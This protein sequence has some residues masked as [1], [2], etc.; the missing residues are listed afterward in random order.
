MRFTLATASILAESLVFASSVSTNDNTNRIQHHDSSTVLVEELASTIQE[1]SM[2]RMDRRG[3]LFLS[4]KPKRFQRTSFAQQL[5]NLRQEKTAKVECDPTKAVKKD[6]DVGVLGVCGEYQYCMESVDSTLG[7][8]CQ[9]ETDDE[10]IDVDFSPRN[11]R[12]LRHLQEGVA[13]SNPTTTE[14]EFSYCTGYEDDEYCTCVE[15]LSVGNF[16]ITCRYEAEYCSYFSPVCTG[17]NYTEFCG[18][19]RLTYFGI[20]GSLGYEFW[21]VTSHTGLD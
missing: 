17:A 5:Q 18:G 9:P 7:G 13:T 20:S 14:T 6:I 19:A 10:V 15:D 3:Q 21:L 1:S 16:N 2:T 4:K 11:G 8:Y 12:G